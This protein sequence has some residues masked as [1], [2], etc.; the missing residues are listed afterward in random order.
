MFVNYSTIE[1]W[2]DSCLWMNYSKLKRIKIHGLSREP[3]TGLLARLNESAARLHE[4]EID[5]LPLL[6]GTGQMEYIFEELK[7]LSIDLIQVVDQAGQPAIQQEMPPPLPTVKFE[8]KRLTK[9]FLGKWP[10][11]IHF[12]EN[13]V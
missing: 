4:L 3:I 6:E 5:T 12:P 2:D 10:C 8:A 11:R 13:S 7:L 1:T 9:V